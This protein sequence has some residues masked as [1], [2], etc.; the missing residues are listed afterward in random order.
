MTMLENKIIHYLECANT[1]KFR[2]IANKPTGLS[3][4]H[5]ICK[6]CIPLDSSTQVKCDHCGDINKIQLDIL[7]N[8]QENRIAIS[9]IN[10]TLKDLFKHIMERF[11]ASFEQF[12]GI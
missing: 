4:G 1:L 5:F 11:E 12:K 3:C 8:S 9:L 10:D 2:H 6:E 7:K